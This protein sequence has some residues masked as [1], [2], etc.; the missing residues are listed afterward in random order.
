MEQLT[1]QAVAEGIHLA[2]AVAAAQNSDPRLAGKIDRAVLL[3][4]FDP[5]A[6]SAPA[7]ALATRQ[8]QQLH[9]AQQ[10]LQLPENSS[11]N[12]NEGTK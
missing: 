3:Q 2:D 10:A 1:R 4:L 6:A 9:A 5:L 7:Q 12:S 11:S 8:L